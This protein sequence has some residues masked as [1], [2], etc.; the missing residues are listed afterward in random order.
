[1]R[2]LIWLNRDWYPCEVVGIGGHL[3]DM[4]HCVILWGDIAVKQDIVSLNIR[5]PISRVQISEDKHDVESKKK[6]AR[7][8]D[9]LAGDS[10]TIYE[11]VNLDRKE[12][13]LEISETVDVDISAIQITL[14][15][16]SGDVSGDIASPRNKVVL[17]SPTEQTEILNFKSK[18]DILFETES[19]EG[20]TTGTIEKLKTFLEDQRSTLAQKT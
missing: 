1:M 2:G 9:I 15:S 10:M 13:K 5:V 16:E 17:L 4:Y 12:S 14:D 8:F 7:L 19:N 3:F 6:K 20:I 11:D 18:F